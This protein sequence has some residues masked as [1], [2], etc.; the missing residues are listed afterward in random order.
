M[1]RDIGKFIKDSKREHVF[2]LLVNNERIW[3]NIFESIYSKKIW[4][5]MDDKFLFEIKATEEDKQ[6]GLEF[7]HKEFSFRIVKNKD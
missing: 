1:I 3:I 2:I 5:A 6:K 4:L 7:E